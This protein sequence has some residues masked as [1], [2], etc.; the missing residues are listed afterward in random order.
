MRIVLGYIAVRTI[1]DFKGIWL[2]SVQAS[3]LWLYGL[4]NR[5]VGLGFSFLVKGSWS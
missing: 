5:D 4:W 3:V 1:K 2:R